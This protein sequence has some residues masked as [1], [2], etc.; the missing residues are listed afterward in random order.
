MTHVTSHRWGKPRARFGT[1]RDDPVRP[2]LPPA[3]G[4]GGIHP[5]GPSGHSW[6]AGRT[7]TVGSGGTLTPR[8][9]QTPHSYRVHRRRAR[10][11]GPPTLGLDATAALHSASIPDATLGSPSDLTPPSPAVGCCLSTMTAVGCPRPV[12]ACQA[13]APS[14]TGR[15][16][17][18]IALPMPLAPRSRS[19]DLRARTVGSHSGELGRPLRGACARPDGTSVRELTTFRYRR[20]AGHLGRAQGC[21]T[22]NGGDTATSSGCA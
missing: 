9:R 2:E 1:H 11:H 14:L 7:T 21:L 4:L 6:V 19:F 10:S 13:L 8:G 3:H 16:D 17:L 12:P 15:L 22:V 20:A 5:W 18:Y